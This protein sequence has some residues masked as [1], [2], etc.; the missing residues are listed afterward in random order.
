LLDSLRGTCDVLLAEVEKEYEQHEPN[1]VFL[2]LLFSALLIKL[3]NARPNIFDKHLS[4]TRAITFVHFISLLE[5]NFTQTHD[6]KML[7][8][9]Y[10]SL[11][12][13]CKLAT[14]QTTK[15]LIDAHTILEAKR[16]LA[17]EQIRVKQLADELGFDEVTSFV[18][19]LKKNTLL[20]PSQFKES[21]KG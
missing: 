7:N 11:N 18:K 20:T 12:H 16:K 6:A 19:Y 9:T 10:K 4:E 1:F 13:I 14:N 17:F 3:T 8:M 15:Q 5:Q 21:T 2:Q